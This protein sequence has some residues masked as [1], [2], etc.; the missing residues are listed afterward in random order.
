MTPT[1]GKVVIV[2]A[3]EQVDYLQNPARR[4][5]AASPAE[6]QTWCSCGTPA[7]SRPILAAAGP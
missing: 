2:D 5:R 4:P 1:L 7:G 3:D 6:V